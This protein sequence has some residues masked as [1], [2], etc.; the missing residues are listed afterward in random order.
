LLGHIAG[1]DL[2]IDE[3]RIG[4]V[5]DGV[6]PE[7]ISKYVLAF[8]GCRDAGKWDVELRFF[9]FALGQAEGLSLIP[10]VGDGRVWSADIGE[11]LIE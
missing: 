8:S 2:E 4:V 11:L 3:R 10:G 6:R 1:I 7:L 5:A 9:V